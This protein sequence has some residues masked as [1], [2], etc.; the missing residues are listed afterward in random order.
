MN[1]Q[2]IIDAAV[3]GVREFAGTTRGAQMNIV[4]YPIDDRVVVVEYDSERGGVKCFIGI[5]G[6]HQ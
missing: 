1:R 2:E 6:H 3:K 4:I 5:G